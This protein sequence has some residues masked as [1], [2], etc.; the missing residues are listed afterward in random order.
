MTPR[1]EPNA[2]PP[3]FTDWQD[4][5]GTYRAYVEDFKDSQKRFSDEV[6]LKI[7]LQRLGFAGADLSS[8]MTYV[9]EST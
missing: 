8:E 4:W 7:R 2:L 5:L 3:L 9:K 1:T 6:R